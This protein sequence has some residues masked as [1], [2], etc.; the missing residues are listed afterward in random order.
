M[1]SRKN[2]QLVSVNTQCHVTRHALYTVII[3]GLLV[4]SGQLSANWQQPLDRNEVDAVAAIALAEHAGGTTGWTKPS[5]NSMEKSLNVDQ[6]SATVNSLPH[7]LGTQILLI[8]LQEQKQQPLH[9][10][11]EVF[12]FDYQRGITERKLV[13]VERNLLVDSREISSVHLPLSETE[14]RYGTELIWSNSEVSQR[15]ADEMTV[16]GGHGDITGL[17]NAVSSLLTR[18]SIWVPDNPGQAGISQCDSQRCALIS[19]FTT[20]NYHFSIEPVVNL[21]SGEIFV[22]IAQ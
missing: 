19:I 3:A 16:S 14:I 22:D 10:L 9:R 4:N 18:V 1:N 2:I 11:A 7:P 13:D 5:G 20:H 12:L 8:E 21:M 17:D 15:V 6:R